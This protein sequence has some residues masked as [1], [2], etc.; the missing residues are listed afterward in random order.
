MNSII[1]DNLLA[2]FGSNALNALKFIRNLS[3]N[4]NNS[5]II[6]NNPNNK[7][8]IE[9]FVID[10]YSLTG[11]SNNPKELI[12]NNSK[13]YYIRF[14]I[15]IYNKST[16]QLY[17]NTY[18]SPLFPV[19]IKPNYSIEFDIKNPF[20]FY[21]LSQEP[22]H[23]YILVQIIL[24]ETNQEDVILQEKCQGWTLLKLK[25][26]RDNNESQEEKTDAKI[27]RGTPRDLIY[28]N[29]FIEYQGARLSYIA[30]KYPQLELI[31]FLLPTNI[32]MAY[33]EQLPGLRLRSL[34]QYQT[35][36]ALKTVE[37]ISA[38]VKNIIIE[39]NPDLENHILDFGKEYRLNKYKVN[40]NEFNKVYIKERR[41]K[42]GMHNTWK[43][44]NS[45]GIQN[46][47]TLTKISKNK[48]Q[49]NGVLMIDKFFSDHLSCSAVVM[50]L[51]YVLT[52]PINGP[53]KEE[54]LSLILG[55]HLYVPE[56]I[57]EGNYSK[58]KLL[59]F[60][61]P[62]N[63]INGEKMFNLAN[64][65]Y[66]NIRI[67]YILS[68]NATVNVIN[69]GEMDELTKQKIIATE[70][71]L[72]DQNNQ[73]ILNKV[74]QSSDI[75][76]KIDDN[77]SKSKNIGDLISYKGEIEALRKQLA[78]TEEDK[79]T[80]QLKLN[81]R[82]LTLNNLQKVIGKNDRGIEEGRFKK[83]AEKKIEDNIEEKPKEI[84]M[85][86]LK[87]NP[88]YK[89][90][91]EFK[92]NKESYVK[93]LE[94]KFEILKEIQKPKV[95]EYEMPIKN[96]SSRDKSNLI[97]KGIKD[98]VLNEPV[99]SY[100]DYSLDKELC[101]REL[102][103]NFSF[104]FLT[105]KPSRLF[106]S[107]L[108]NVPEKI[109]F[110]FD[111]FN[112][113]KLYTPICNVTRPEDVKSHNYYY[114]NNPLLLKKENINTN[115]VFLNDTKPEVLI[116]VRY[117]PSIDT[118]ID[119]RDFV[120]YMLYRR[121]VVRIKDVQ[122]CLN[123]G[124]IKIPLTD[125]IQGKDKIQITKE[126]EIFDDN[127]NL[128]GYIQVLMTASKY[129]TLRPYTYDRNK[130]T[131][132]N[133]KEGYNTLSKKKKVKAEQMD[134][135]KIMTQNKDFYNKAINSLQNQNNNLDE[136][137]TNLINEMSQSRLRKLRI[138]PE[139]EKKLRVMRY[140]N[141]KNDPNY[142]SKM[143]NTNYPLNSKIQ[144][145][146]QRLN[147][148]KQKQTNDDQFMNT[149][150]NC[151]KFR[152]YNRDEVLSKVSQ[153]NHKNVY[154][155]S[156]IMG[157]P[158]F[159]NYS[160][161]NDSSLDLL[162]H[163]TIERIKKNKKDDNNFRQSKIVEIISTPLEW[164]SIVE[165]ENLKRPNNYEKISDNLD[166]IIKPGETVPLVVKLL[167]YVENREEDNYSITIH[168]KNGQPLYY[169]LINIKKVFPIYDHIF[170]YNISSKKPEQRVVLVNPFSYTKTSEMLSNLYPTN[171][172][173][174]LDEDTHN[175]NFRIEPDNFQHDFVLFFYSDK[176]RTNLYLTWKIEINWVNEYIKMHGVKGK[177]VGRE[178]KIYTNPDL[179]AGADNAGNNVTLQLFTDCPDVVIFPPESKNH[180]TLKPN[181]VGVKNFYLYPRREGNSAVINCVN[182]Y[183]RELYNSWMVKYSQD[184]PEIDET[185]EIKVIIGGKNVLD[186][187]YKNPTGK[188]MVLSF[189]SANEDIMEVIDRVAV[190]NGNEEKIIKLRF[191]DEGKVDKKEALLFIS[192][193][194]NDFCRTIIFKINFEAN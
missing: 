30:N 80:I 107:D 22:K 117:D 70:N 81:Q 132:I 149:L 36:E 87:D 105:F 60:T 26:D 78:Q 115:S 130:F 5:R 17:G 49:S 116:E 131:N 102:A 57:S 169:L 119:F 139:L 159:F 193:D 160:V 180:F 118:S 89:E 86:S 85:I 166:M 194:S 165:K 18:R 12:I 71:A 161:F 74:Q 142:N 37:F 38:Y 191:N 148:L 33:N 62:G 55:Y 141:S 54:D 20:C 79:I 104:Q 84:N 188:F 77:K 121:L 181:S 97:K 183:T 67:S 106:Y 65:E 179:N 128:R 120:K 44:I 175:F 101:Q 32:I 190:F 15:S 173:L 98:L 52:I 147:E 155:I 187:E 56:K 186:Y 43:F 114:F 126:Y 16:R 176:E 110:F 41:I 9:G 144:L 184:M 153:E 123:V 93:E 94:E 48:L 127:F 137:N 168:K 69:Q 109:Q 145:E 143:A 25:T 124:F 50:E 7:D 157:Q 113:G 152:D 21:V 1:P 64:S 151:E 10:I 82:E 72:I 39:I 112:E 76:E 83:P 163:I 29:N 171:I 156:L 178:I 140:F 146:E 6:S 162:C 90:F 53:Q 189:Y 167:S 68:Q 34:P 100:I 150:R 35:R 133:S 134:I 158:I 122:K 174:A 129:N 103:T 27:N 4:M 46:S 92:K 73:I 138:A 58:E 111:F 170:H 192:D 66:K 11:L 136:K 24:V 28:T 51:E 63:T 3:K 108:R 164:R 45:S 185:E 42:C 40:E 19:E 91:I 23:E 61:G 47:I 125:L 172:G 135:D 95:R 88:E 8:K 31:N 75:N 13:N 182:I 96:I 177:K 14:F 59:M 154:N 2:Y 99:N